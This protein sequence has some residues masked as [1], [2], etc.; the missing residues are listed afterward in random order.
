MPSILD[1]ITERETTATAAATT[2]RDQITALTE[3]LTRTET[4]LTELAITRTTLLRLA[5]EAETAASLDTTVTSGPYQQILTVFATATSAIRA[6]D[7]CLALN[8]DTS[9]NDV[10]K[11][12]ARLKRLVTRHILTEDEPGLFTLAPPENTANTREQDP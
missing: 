9:T 10:E 4:E 11:M 6:K 12:R 7:V 8:T 1:L 3:Q 5:G 2:L